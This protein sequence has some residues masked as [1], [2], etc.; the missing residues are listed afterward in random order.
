[1]ETICRFLKKYLDYKGHKDR[2]THIFIVLFIL[3][4]S[5][6]LIS[7]AISNL[8][9]IPFAL[10]TFYYAYR[11]KIKPRIHPLSY[12]FFLLF[13]LMILSYF[14][15]IDSSA[16]K[17]QLLGEIRFF[18][19]PLLFAF[20]PPLRQNDRKSIL[21][22]FA[23]ILTVLSLVFI[24]IGF[25]RYVKTGNSTFLSQHPLVNPLNLNRVFVSLFIS[26]TIFH[27]ILN[28]RKNVLWFLEF[29]VLSIFLLLLSSKAIIISSL[30]ILLFVLN[31]HRKFK[32]LIILLLFPLVIGLSL[33]INKGFISE[34]TPRYHE[35]LHNQHFGKGYY[36][37]G[38][39]LRLLYT[40]FLIELNKEDTVFFT[41]YGL[42][43]SQLKIKEKIAGFN[44]PIQIVNFDA[45]QS[46]V[47]LVP[48]HT[49]ESYLEELKKNPEI[50]HIQP[51]IKKAAIIKT[52]TDFEGIVVKGVDSTYNWQFFKDYL[53]EGTFPK[54]GEELS[55]EALVSKTLSE[56]LQLAVGQEIKIW[57]V[58]E[59][60]TKPPLV[61]A[62]K[63]TGIY[64]T[65]FPEFD[66]SFVLADM[67]HLQK[68]NKWQ[69]EEV[70]GFEVFVKDFKRIKEVGI[71]VYRAI[72]SHLDSK[73]VL[74][75]YPLIFE[76]VS[77]FDGNIAAIIG[78]M[79]LVAGF[80][81]ITVLL[82][83][84]LE[85]TN[86][87]GILKAMGSSNWQIRKIFMYH[88]T[89]LVLRGLFWGNLIGLGLLFL[90]KQF[91]FIA[92]NP[93]TYYVNSAPVY[94]HWSY[95]LLLNVGVVL[96]SYFMLLLPSYFITR[97]SPM[98][99]I[100]FE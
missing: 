84:I 57:F 70:G 54:I 21:N 16:T 48:I 3:Q 87:I 14:W 69:P 12:W 37:N 66:N 79:I 34:M 17:H 9:L 22:I 59:D 13:A 90:Q 85:Q 20:I 33:K 75:Q 94:L 56:K 44:G 10:Y 52:E 91:H 89:Y 81:I 62:L 42:A 68:I 72:P 51:F 65:G 15:S 30:V 40:R 60:L 80:N 55:G 99:V 5:S 23:F 26:T 38:A 61:R 82:V 49:D 11:F 8:L 25:Y 6:Q 78:I 43:A 63:I 77:L 2:H 27:L 31:I 35:I 19:I 45:N 50:T 86:M 98:K 36:F 83:L 39:E 88:A 4:L 1:M 97:I 67:R 74:E 18:S 46:L 64:N 71:E 47:S 28:Y 32:F 92:L 73:T 95:I 7:P 29:L 24:F 100:R 76:W 96:I 58:R 53:I 93:E 41:G